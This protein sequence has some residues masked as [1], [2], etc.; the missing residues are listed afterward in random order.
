MSNQAGIARAGLQLML[1]ALALSCARLATAQQVNAP[2]N[3]P[4]TPLKRPLNTYRYH[5]CTN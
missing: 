1:I 5:S 2:P 3:T 4:V